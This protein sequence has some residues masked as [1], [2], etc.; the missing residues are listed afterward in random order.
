MFHHA[1]PLLVFLIH[2]LS[3]SFWNVR[4]FI[5]PYKNLL[6]FLKQR[7]K[8]MLYLFS[9][10]WI[11]LHSPKHK[12]LSIE[13]NEKWNYLIVNV[14]H[15]EKQHDSHTHTHSSLCQSK[16]SYRPLNNQQ[17]LAMQP[18]S[19]IQYI[20]QH[21]L[22]PS[23]VYEAVTFFPAPICRLASGMPDKKRCWH[24][25]GVCRPMEI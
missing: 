9:P 18:N 13:L 12:R 1:P 11:R 7:Y 3:R 21:R 24:L 2:P 19:T 6:S 5:T 8:N 25:S 22:L 17:Q 10:L 20:L 4:N 23:A 16:I 15:V 14:S